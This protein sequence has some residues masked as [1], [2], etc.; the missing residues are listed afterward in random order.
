MATIVAG[1]GVDRAG[2]KG[3]NDQEV[4][5]NPGDRRHDRDGDHHGGHERPFKVCAE[6]GGMT[7]RADTQMPDSVWESRKGGEVG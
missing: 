1:A 3:Y 5:W 7:H 4:F 6:E 2:A